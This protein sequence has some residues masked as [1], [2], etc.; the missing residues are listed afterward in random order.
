MKT[1]MPKTLT[2][3]I[4]RLN[5]EIEI[6]DLSV[7]Y[8]DRAKQNPDIDTPENAIR[9][10]AGLSDEEIGKL[11]R[12]EIAELYRLILELT[13]PERKGGEEPDDGGKG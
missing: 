6:W 9:H 12:H 10:S 2:V 13:F 11:G 1:I 5:K 8:I 4:E 3:K 7:E